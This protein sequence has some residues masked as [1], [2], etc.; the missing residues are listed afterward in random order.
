MASEGME[1]SR[2]AI[3]KAEVEVGF[4]MDPSTIPAP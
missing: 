1:I 3:V 2:A 4:S